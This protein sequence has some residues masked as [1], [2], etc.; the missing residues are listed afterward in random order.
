MP[1]GS[2]RRHRAAV[3]RDGTGLLGH[4]LLDCSGRFAQDLDFFFQLSDAVLGGCQ[5]SGSL[6][7][8][9]GFASRSIKS[10]LFHWYK[11]DWAIPNDAATSTT[12]RP[13]AIRAKA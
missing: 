5:L 8:R 6:R 2:G 3:L 11:Q 4:Y 9:A 12:V 13:D 1:A 10:W 7:L